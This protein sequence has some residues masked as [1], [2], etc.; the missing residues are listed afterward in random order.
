ME[1][2]LRRLLGVKALVVRGAQFEPHGVEVEVRPRQRRARCGECGRPSPGYDTSASRLWRHLSL[3]R[4][5]FWLRYAPR[6]VLCREHGVKVERVPWAA[7]GS[8]FTYEFDEMTAWLAQR[9]DKTATC[10]LMGINWR[11]VGTVVQRVVQAKLDPSRLEELY[12]IG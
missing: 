10:R 1:E 6:R 12:I 11:T 9:M 4:T 5:A 7:H 3:G 8:H 2:L